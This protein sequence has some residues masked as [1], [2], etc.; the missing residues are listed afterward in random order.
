ME[1]TA[2]II[3]LSLLVT[4][5]WKSI[6]WPDFERSLEELSIICTLSRKVYTMKG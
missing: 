2:E 4:E 6:R 5:Q 3:D 1:Q